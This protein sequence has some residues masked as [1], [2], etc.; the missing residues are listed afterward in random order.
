MSGLLQILGA[1][2]VL[3][4]FASVQL[5][6]MR[7]SSYPS[8]ALNIGGSALLAA[9][10]LLDEQWGFLLLEA[11]WALVSLWALGTRLAARPMETAA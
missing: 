2:A 3:A 1:L 10:A 8:L 7:P 9:L 11:S 4:A 6:V 5:G